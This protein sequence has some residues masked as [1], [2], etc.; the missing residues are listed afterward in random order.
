MT[1]RRVGFLY[2]SFASASSPVRSSPGSD[3]GGVG[4]LRDDLAYLA[5]GRLDEATLCYVKDIHEACAEKT[6]LGTAFDMAYRVVKKT[7]GFLL[8]AVVKGIV[9]I[10]RVVS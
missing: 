3:G 8:P 10:K 4:S 2:R 5:H 6:G 1:G 9:N 7:G